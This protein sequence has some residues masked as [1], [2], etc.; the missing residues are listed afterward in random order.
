MSFEPTSS[1]GELQPIPGP[2]AFGEDRTRFLNLV[3]I[4]SVAEFKLMYVGS[5]LG[6]ALGYA[7]AL[8]RPLLTFAVI[9]IVFSEVLR[10]GDTVPYY[11]AMLL[12]N[13]SLSSSSSPTRARAP[14]M[15]WSRTRGCSARSSSPGPRFR[16]R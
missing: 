14:S 2:T 11:A 6:S 8:A 16:C 12:F 15:P 3:W 7:W 4:N 13:L 9:Y 5:A 10:I 1:P